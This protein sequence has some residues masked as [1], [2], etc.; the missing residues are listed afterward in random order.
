MLW[1]DD[2]EPPVPTSQWKPGQTVEY[3]RTRFV[4]VVPYSGDAT[5]E[6]GLYRRRRAACR[7]RA[8]CR[9]IASRRPR[10]YKVATL[11]FLPRVRKHLRHLQD[12]LASGRV[13]SRRPDDSWKWTQ[14]IG[15]LVASAI[16]SATSRCYSSTTRGRTSFAASRSRSP[17]VPAISSSGRSGRLRSG[18]RLRRIPI[19]AAQL[20]AERH[21][22]FEDRGRPDFV[23]AKLP[24][25][26][27]DARELGSGSITSSWKADKPGHARH[28]PDRRRSVPSSA[29]GGLIA[30]ACLRLAATCPCLA[31]ASSAAAGY[32]PAH[33]RAHA[34]RRVVPV[35][36]G[37]SW[38]SSCAAAARFA[39]RAIWWPSSCPMKCPSRG[40]SRIEALAASPRRRAAAA[41]RA[42][43][44]ARC[45]PHRRPKWRRRL[46]TAGARGRAR[47]VELRAAGRVARRARWA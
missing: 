22:G 43:S 19:T 40:P 13:R 47:R 35:R 7:C 9:R 17:S 25:G 30:S 45:R 14:K 2:H 12:R 4:P 33:Q 26:G 1:N 42:A 36:G 44:C 6:V 39:R 16:P 20:G 24:A 8:G 46:D 32:R 34:D 3:T 18:V 29:A 38:C 41:R 31:S 15:G 5:V 28:A 27:R 21:G 37:R 10:A 23:P 11:E